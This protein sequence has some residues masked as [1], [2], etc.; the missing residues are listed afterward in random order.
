MIASSTL[1]GLLLTEK[2]SAMIERI[3][4]ING[5]IAINKTPMIKITISDISQVRFSAIINPNSKTKKQ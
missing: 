3:R 5:Q 4:L 1:F 2:T